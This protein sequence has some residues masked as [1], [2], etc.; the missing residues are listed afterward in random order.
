MSYVRFTM[1]M[2]LSLQ[3]SKTICLLF[4]IVLITLFTTFNLKKFPSKFVANGI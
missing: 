3:L 4:S 1:A 2:T